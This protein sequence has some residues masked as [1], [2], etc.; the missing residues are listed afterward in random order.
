MIGEVAV[1]AVPVLA[2]VGGIGSVRGVLEAGSG[3]LPVMAARAAEFLH[4]MRGGGSEIQFGVGVRR[5]RMSVAH[6]G[7]VAASAAR[8][9]HNRVPIFV[10]DLF[11]DQ[12]FVGVL[13]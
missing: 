12:I 1:F 4:L 13:H 3:A 5:K 7:A 8:F 10:D 2:D 6:L 11:A 9:L